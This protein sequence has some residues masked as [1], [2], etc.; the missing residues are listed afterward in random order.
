VGHADYQQH[1]ILKFW[2]RICFMNL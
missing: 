1:L 2:K